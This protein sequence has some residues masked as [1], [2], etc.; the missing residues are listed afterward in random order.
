MANDEQK[1]RPS[2]PRRFFLSGFWITAGVMAVKGWNVRKPHPPELVHPDVHFE[3]SDINARDVVLTGSAVL[4]FT[5]VVILL[6][7][8]FM[9]HFEHVHERESPPPLPIAAHGTP[10]PPEPRLQDMPRRDLQELR[11]REDFELHRYSV[12]NA[13][14]IVTIPID[15]AMDLL[16]QRG[17]PA[18]KAPVK[19]MFYWPRAGSRRTG[20]EGRVEPEPR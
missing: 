8:P 5:Y 9:E 16:A 2:L 7:Y 14:G 10:V 12:L 6:L 18:Q 3:E 19:N 13:N 20:L 1:P 15:R 11:A 17:I 4:L